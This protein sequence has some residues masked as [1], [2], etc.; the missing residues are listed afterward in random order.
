[1]S[2]KNDRFRDLVNDL[3][4]DATGRMDPDLVEWVRRGRKIAEGILTGM[5][6][7]PPSYQALILKLAVTELLRPMPQK[8]I[9]LWVLALA[10]EVLDEDRQDEG[11]NRDDLKKDND[12][13]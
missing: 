12:N 6:S 10:R 2:S 1:M 13:D 3:K 11:Y 8:V 4:A 5:D 9:S 7:L